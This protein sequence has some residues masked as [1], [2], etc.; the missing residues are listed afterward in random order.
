MSAHQET[1]G[2]QA[3]G[4]IAIDGRHAADERRT[5]GI[6]GLLCA[7]LGLGLGTSGAWGG[8]YSI[9]L[10]GPMTLLVLGALLAYLAAASRRLGKTEVTA[11]AGLVALA[12]LALVSTLWAESGD[13][14]FLEAHRWAL[15]AALFAL[16]IHL[17][18]GADRARVLLGAVTAGVVAI[19]L[20]TV[21]RLLAGET[22]LFIDGRLFDPV[23]Y[24]NGTGA[25][26]LLGV[27]PLLVAA[28]RGR[29]L[30]ARA[31]S[32]G[33]VSMLLGLLL[34]TVSRGGLL[35]LLVGVVVVL[36][37]AP[38]RLRR[39]WLLL[40]VGVSFGA[41]AAPIAAVYSR[42][43]GPNHE[44]QANAITSSGV[45]VLGAAAL[46]AVLWLLSEL[47]YAR[48]EHDRR[49]MSV[50]RRIGTAAVAAT[51]VAV[52]ASAAIESHSLSSY[53]KRQWHAFS[54]DS[55]FGSSATRLASGAGNRYD[56][57]RVALDE[58]RA[59]PVGGVGA[60]NY[61]SE[62][63]LLRHTTEDIRQPHSIELQALAE[64]G[65]LGAA[66]LAVFVLG[67]V[68]ILVRG[69]RGRASRGLTLAGAGM[70]AAWLT[71]TSADWIHLIPGV[72]GA[73][74]CV[75]A[76]V[77]AERVE[78]AEV[79]RT[80]DGHGFDRRRLAVVGMASFAI[81][82]TAI[83]VGRLTLASHYRSE[84]SNALAAGRP[85]RAIES[86]NSSLSL[87]PGVLS[88]IY[89]K[90]AALARLNRYYPARTELETAVADEP[91]NSV[92]H[93]LLGDLA[94]RHGEPEVARREYAAAAALDP[95]NA[96]LSAL[97]RTV[98]SPSGGTAP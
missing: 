90:A 53:A 70:F 5:L 59:H 25:Y 4:G 3:V 9:S 77:A 40:T 74:I 2:T 28:E 44:A 80:V 81:L 52:V 39:L 62:Y 46:A 47:L 49:V 18:T 94:V 12:V 73:V 29:W 83:G 95:R 79:R 97:A 71:Q 6:S 48:I 92:P 35:G 37:A 56:Y 64:L 72:T 86:A 87:E 67:A 16:T 10:W 33:F 76:A 42:A 41:F 61:V 20:I 93:A 22:T 98:H 24:T 63:F 60:G 89:V 32:A 14:A 30:A 58:F 15:Y 1:Y 8:L 23:G 82:V 11:L 19:G 34:L 43:T 13:E 78:P 84:A 85:R 69:A 45:A 36:A 57:W 17:A 55:G 54:T 21:G 66:A 27:F 68:W 38:G 91:H 7:V 31:L 65:L 88:A 26:F 51:L 50:L 96:E 75:V